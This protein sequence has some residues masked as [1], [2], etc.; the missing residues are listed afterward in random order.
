MHFLMKQSLYLW[1]YFKNNCVVT[2]LHKYKILPHNFLLL[3]QLTQLICCWTNSSQ[4]NVRMYTW[5]LINSDKQSKSTVYKE[6][7]IGFPLT[8]YQ[9]GTYPL[10]VVRDNTLRNGVMVPLNWKPS[11]IPNTSCRNKQSF[12]FEYWQF[13]L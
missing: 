6:F 1:G 2:F 5:H 12:M 9:D 3:G 8:R 13:L 11:Y 4:E 7:N 10:W